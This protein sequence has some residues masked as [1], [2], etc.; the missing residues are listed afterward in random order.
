ML[1]TLNGLRA[2]RTWYTDNLRLEE[3]DGDLVLIQDSTT[4]HIATIEGEALGAL[5]Q[6]LKR[7]RLGLEAIGTASGEKRLGPCDKA[8]H[9]L[10]RQ[11]CPDE[12]DVCYL[13]VCWEDPEWKWDMEDSVSAR[14]IVCV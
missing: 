3:V 11:R 12:C 5:R 13:T 6:S 14:H 9:M 7:N 4:T 10:V 8:Y 2:A 1:R